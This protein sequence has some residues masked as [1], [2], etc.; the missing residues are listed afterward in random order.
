MTARQTYLIHRL[1]QDDVTPD[2]YREY[3]WLEYGPGSYSHS[4]GARIQD[5]NLFVTDESLR[6]FKLL[7]RW[8]NPPAKYARQDLH[9][10][11][12]FTAA[13][14]AKIDR[15][16]PVVTLQMFV[17][18]FGARAIAHCQA[19]GMDISNPGENV[20][21]RRKR[22]N[23]ERMAAAREARRTPQDQATPQIREAESVLASLR[24]QARQEDFAHKQAVVQAQEEM[25]RLSTIRKVAA[26]E[27]K[28]KIDQQRQTI[29]GLRAS[30]KQPL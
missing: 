13:V 10:P 9:S 23:R 30:T 25:I 18:D 1:Q 21:D 3:I 26:G 7:K 19:T 29:L 12:L 16:R 20:D 14:F 27:W 8:W 11:D 28:E 17:D 15:N 4:L 24:E 6:N 2:E 5:L 22:L